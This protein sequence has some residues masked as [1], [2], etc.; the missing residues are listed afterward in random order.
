M[1]ASLMAHIVERANVG[2]VERRNGAGF[3]VEALL[4]LIVF[5]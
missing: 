1:D 3:A 5:R 4:G 2:M